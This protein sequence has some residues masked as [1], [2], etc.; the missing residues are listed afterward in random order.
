[1][2]VSQKIPEIL[3]RQ[4]IALLLPWK[5]GEEII[6]R[7]CNVWDAHI[8]RFTILKCGTG[9]VGDARLKFVT[10]HLDILDRKFGVLLQFQA[11]LATIGSII[12]TG[13]Y[14]ATQSQG[15]YSDGF[16]WIL[17]SVCVLWI[18]DTLLCLA[19]IRRIVWG[20]M[21]TPSNPSVAEQIQVGALRTEVIKRT[22]KFRVAVTIQTF[23]VATVPVMV[24]EAIEKSLD[25]FSVELLLLGIL[26]AVLLTSRQHR[27][28]L[29]KPYDPPELEANQKAA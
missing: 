15:E 27:E 21:S 17:G 5:R 16:K 4:E 29:F 26:I 18:I 14:R 22:A 7:R 3:L 19:G 24:Y 2:S 10:E 23:I 6:E 12:F 13:L 1:M 28:R 8:N 9:Q 25:L 11:L 20:D